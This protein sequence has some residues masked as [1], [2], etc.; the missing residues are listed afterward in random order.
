MGII[1]LRINGHNYTN[2][3]QII[4]IIKD[5]NFHWLVDS[6]V[7]NAI[8]EI[9]NNT[10]IWIQGDYLSGRWEYGIFKEG[11]FF[12]TWVNGIFENGNFSGKWISGINNAEK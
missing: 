8:I 2:K 12:G 7:D 10:V 6:E 3:H 1:E 11:N 5:N 4:K 9:K